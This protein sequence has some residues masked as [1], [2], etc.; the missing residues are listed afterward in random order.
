MSTDNPVDFLIQGALLI[1][2]KNFIPINNG[3][4][5]FH[6][7]HSSNCIFTASAMLESVTL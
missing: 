3:Q 7:I 5:I 2:R 1:Y 4:L 6:G